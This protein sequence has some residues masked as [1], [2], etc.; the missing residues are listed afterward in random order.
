MS[1]MQ[2]INGF[3]LPDKNRITILGKVLR[4]S[5]LDELP[6][7]INILKSEMS[8]V[9]PRPLPVTY[10]NLMKDEQKGRYQVRPGM[11]GLAQIMG[12]NSLS[13]K[14][15]IHYDLKYIERITFYGD[16]LIL[17]KTFRYIFSNKANDSLGDQSIDRFIPNFDQ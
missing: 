14:L 8:L 12:R 6:N 7:L 5:S 4:F 2:S 11:T 16:L 3:Q 15:K 1:D 10:F 9:G 17:F 13:W